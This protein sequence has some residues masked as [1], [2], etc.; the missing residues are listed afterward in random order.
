M[1]KEE[2]GHDCIGVMVSYFD[3]IR[4][5]RVLLGGNPKQGSVT[6]QGLA[7]CAGPIDFTVTAYSSTGQASEPRTVTAT[8]RH[9]SKTYTARAW[10]DI[11]LTAD[12]LTTNAQ[13]ESEGPLSNLTDGDLFD[14]F[15][16][17]WH[18]VADVNQLH[19]IIIDLEERTPS[20]D[21]L[22]GYAPRPGK[23]GE[24][25]KAARISFSE[26]GTVWSNPV[27]VTFDMPKKSGVRV[28]SDFF[29]L[30]A[31]TRYLK[32]EPTMRFDGTDLTALLG[33]PGGDRYF[34]MAELWLSKV[35]E[36]NEYDPEVEILE[37]IKKNREEKTSK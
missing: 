13:E 14:Y 28:N 25:V 2:P 8:S 16:S 27:T 24:S 21:M 22:L 3:P 9:M 12:R 32:M 33:Q 30:P 1:A 35:T 5:H 29:T 37:I 23:E 7:E 11:P 17:D 4:N 15:H 20:Q 6:A 19:H 34:H 31:N 18:G 36:Y 10:Q 26:D